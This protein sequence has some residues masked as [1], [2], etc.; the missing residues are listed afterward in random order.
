V[1]RLTFGLKA[2][3]Q[4]APLAD[5]RA[6][7]RLAEDGGF[8]SIWLFDHF[9][10]MSRTARTGDILEAWT[11]L[12]ALAQATDRIRI[13]TLVTGNLYRPPGV[14]A[15]MAV[16][17][18]HLSGGRLEMGI[19]AGGDAEADRMLG[20]APAP[21]RLRI[22]RLDEA[23]QVLRL[24]WTEPVASFAG[25]HYQLVDA[26][27]DPKPVQPGGPR[28]WIGSSGERYGL[29]VVAERAD[30]WLNASM[31]AADPAELA[32]LTHL[33]AV[34][35]RHCADVGRDPA[36]IR[37]AVQVFQPADDDE[38]LRAAERLVDAGFTDV[39]VAPVG[40]LRQA[41]RA[42][43]LLPRLRELG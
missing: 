16:T 32:R 39:V 43:G 18:D 9:L 34:L 22:E 25:R 42:V 19:G 41:E 24:L 23:C 36:T 14:L 29:R 5:Q 11:L 27:A 3:Q 28:I 13:G 21:A 31:A 33:S 40:G 26:L 6:V 10:P 38:T 37:R 17:V 30:V 20:I 8:D 15:K 4:H 2:S 7:W 35:D 12:A 1:S